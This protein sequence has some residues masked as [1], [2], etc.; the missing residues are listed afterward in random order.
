M[1]TPRTRRIIHAALAA[2]VAVASGCPGAGDPADAASTAATATTGEP[3]PTS[4]PDPTG[5]DTGPPPVG[6]WQKAFQAGGAGISCDMSYEEM[7]SSGAPSL[8]FD[9]TQI[10]VGFQQFGDNQDPVFRRFDAGVE[11]YCE[12]HEAQPPDGRAEGITWDGGPT[13]YVVY[14]VVGGGTEFD[15]AGQGSWVSSYGD[16]GASSKVT[17][18]G[19]VAVDGG[20]LVRGT[21][22]PAKRSMG[23]KTN[24]LVPADAV[25]VLAGG[26]LGFTGNSAYSPLNPDRST[27][28]VGME[29]YPSPP[30]GQDSPS[31]VAQ[32]A[33]DFKSM[34]CATTWSCSMVKQPCP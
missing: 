24:T 34:L 30:A 19:E 6:G 3:P 29:D 7:V 2:A 32:F 33:P 31:V 9:D 14:T 20:K 18:L 27:M 26:V 5:E 1:R 17:F 13:A 25:D 4:G 10:F 12:Y 11:V 15:G 21:F 28:C 8:T 23:T 22:V 16:G